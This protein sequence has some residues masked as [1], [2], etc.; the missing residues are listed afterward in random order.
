MAIFEQV[1]LLYKNG[2]HSNVVD[3]T[4]MVLTAAEN[5]GESCLPCYLRYQCMAMLGFSLQHL[6]QHRRAEAML[7]KSLLYA[8][9]LLKVKIVKASDLYVEGLTEMDVKYAMAECHIAIGQPN[10]ALTVLET[11]GPRSRNVKFNMLL[12]NLYHQTGMERPAATAFKEVLKECPCAVEAAEKLLV[13]GCPVSEVTHIMMSADSPPPDWLITFVKGLAARATRDFST[14]ASTLRQLEEHSP[15]RNN[16]HLLATLGTTYYMQGD[17]KHALP[18][19]QRA[20]ELE[21]LSMEGVSMLGSLYYFDKRIKELETLAGATVAVSENCAHPWILL[22]YYC[23]MSKRT[24]KAIYFAHKACSIDPVSVDG[25]L[26]KGGLLLE[27]K[28]TQEAVLHYREAMHLAPNRFEPYKGLVD[29]YL[30]MRR[31]MEAVSMAS[32]S[33]KLFCH[34]PRALGLYASVLI[35]DGLNA[36]KGKT[37]L[38]KVVKDEPNFLPTVFLMCDVYMSERRYD[39]AQELLL[40]QVNIHPSC[41]VHE[42]LAEIY[43]KQQQHELAQHHSSIAQHYANQGDVSE[44]ISL[45]LSNSGVGSASGG[46]DTDSPASPD[47]TPFD[48]EVEDINDSEGDVELSDLDAVWSDGD[49]SFTGQ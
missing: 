4:P 30:A 38:E 47:V 43:S 29:C 15:L 48:M 24:T 20:H 13:L 19:L 22:A 2:L 46:L 27:L 41:R 9:S 40:R 36:Q 49:F 31:N 45:L 8:K 5:Q 11:I 34:S 17:E 1:K 23:H 25:L 39:K 26:L 18:S 16:A 6:K 28:K 7:K 44:G 14:A 37:I 3:F 42:R 32:N 12:G 35:K 33:T 21:P 10:L